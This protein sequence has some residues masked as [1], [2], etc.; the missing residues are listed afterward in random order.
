MHCMTILILKN[1][2]LRRFSLQNQKWQEGEP[3]TVQVA[4]T[5]RVMSV[6]T[7]AKTV[8]VFAVN[9]AAK[10]AYL[11]AKAARLDATR[12]CRRSKF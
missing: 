1:F 10:A 2:N 3:Q 4:L 6:R 5:A 12:R 11:N 8:K 9:M 7:A